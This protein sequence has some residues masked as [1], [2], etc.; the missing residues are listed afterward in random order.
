MAT[1]IITSTA[2]AQPPTPASVEAQRKA[3]ARLDYMVG[4]WKGE[5]W[6]ERGSR[7]TFQGGERVQR[8]L[9]GL[10]LLVEGDFAGPQAPDVS[11]HKTLGVIYYDPATSKYHFDTWLAAG[12]H[13]RYELEMM[14]DGWRWQIPTPGG[15]IR[16]TMRR[17]TNGEWFEIGERTTDGT[18]WVKFFEMTLRKRTD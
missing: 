6:M 10:A 9:D 11:V 1:A 18:N 17:G 2:Q 15:T 8:K 7:S 13:G 12:S 3:M 4:E 14:D 5:G 16:F